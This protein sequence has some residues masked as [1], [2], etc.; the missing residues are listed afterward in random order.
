MSFKGNSFSFIVREPQKLLYMFLTDKANAIEFYNKFD[1][2]IDS[3]TTLEELDK[4]FEVE[5]NAKGELGYYAMEP[6]ISFSII[7][8]L[9]NK[10]EDFILFNFHTKDDLPFYDEDNSEDWV[11]DKFSIEVGDRH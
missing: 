9:T 11:S 5:E 3:N 8:K 7:N 2:V 4:N 6:F 1:Y 10:K